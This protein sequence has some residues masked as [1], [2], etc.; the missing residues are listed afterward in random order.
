M[1]RVDKGDNLDLPIIQPGWTVSN[2]GYG[3]VTSTTRFK[4]DFG[5]DVD[6]LTNRGTPHP[7]STYSFLK[8]HKYSVSWDSLE[9]A[10]VT[11]DYVGIDPDSESGQMTQPNTSSANGL[12][13]Q[14]ITSHPNFFNNAE[15]Y[16]VALAGPPPYTQDD[17][18]NIAP[19]VNGAPAYLGANGSCFEKA[20]GGRFIGFVKPEFKSLY[21]KTQYLATT[22]TYSGVIYTTQLAYVQALLALLNTAT[23][24]RSWGIF[25]LLP[26][27]APVGTA[28][29]GNKNLLSQINIEEYGALYKVIYEIRYAA[30]GW[31]SLTYVNISE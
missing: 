17:P 1:A 10:T 9:V 6:A 26:E 13:A 5:F 19:I 25:M 22:T 15:P 14:N 11:V 29:W 21:G 8:A 30:D 31:D 12:T 24:T 18:N 7:D 20:N 23:S 16:A 2:D 4:A 27:W 28:E 3:L